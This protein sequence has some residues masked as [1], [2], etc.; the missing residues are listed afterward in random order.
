M[1]LPL[2][3]VISITG[4]SDFFSCKPLSIWIATNEGDGGRSCEDAVTGNDHTPTRP[5]SCSNDFNTQ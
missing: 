5:A 3:I 4:T 1:R 2:A